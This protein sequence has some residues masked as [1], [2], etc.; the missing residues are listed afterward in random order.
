M[1]EVSESKR[2]WRTA[3]IVAGVGLLVLVPLGWLALR[4]WDD[5]IQRRVIAANES[6]ALTNL[7]NIQAAEQLYFE[8]NSQYGTFQ[9]LIDSGIF[10][11]QVSG[12]PPVASGYVFNVR[13]LPKTDTQP[14][15]YSVNADP[16]R[17][18]GRD[19]TGRRHFFVS[20]E[21]IGVRFNESRPATKDDK[22]RP[23]MNSQ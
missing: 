10:Q 18:D 1:A 23:T 15:T 19:A 5:T 7:E 12:D 3:L 6:A 13:V 9:Q 20:S 4:M 11:A 14:P 17:S 22:P 21:V 2:L 16:V 8:T